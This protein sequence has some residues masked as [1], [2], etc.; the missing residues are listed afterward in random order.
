[1]CGFPKATQPL[2]DR[3]NPWELGL[4]PLQ[5][6]MGRGPGGL[7]LLTCPWGLCSHAVLAFSMTEAAM[8]VSPLGN[9]LSSCLHSSCMTEAFPSSGPA[10]AASTSPGFLSKSLPGPGGQALSLLSL[11]HAVAGSGMCRASGRS[12]T[13]GVILDTEPVLWLGGWTGARGCPARR[14]VR[15]QRAGG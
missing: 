13:S 9:G 2:G 14:S 8:T 12:W 6:S 1:M 4:Y 5:A 3:A 10:A 11:S 7:L 15:L